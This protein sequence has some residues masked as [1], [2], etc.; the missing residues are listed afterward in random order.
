[1]SHEV[2]NMIC[3]IEYLMAKKCVAEK[4]GLS[5]SEYIS[6]L[7]HLKDL[8]EALASHYLMQSDLM[9]VCQTLVSTA[10]ITA[11]LSD[12]LP[13]QIE[14]N[15]L[16][17]LI[18]RLIESTDNCYDLNVCRS[19]FVAIGRLYCC[20]GD[21]INAEKFVR[22]AFEDFDYSIPTFQLLMKILDKQEKYSDLLFMM[23]NYLHMGAGYHDRCSFE[24]FYVPNI[25]QSPFESAYR[26]LFD[27]GIKTNY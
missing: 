20:L 25:L 9:F 22:N 26:L 6:L 4:E 10:N 17:S 14:D 11:E 5:K 24:N 12:I 15:D 8:Y 19:A 27:N 3:E 13:T 18:N 2:E 21:Y 7:I 1:M 23:Q 16:H